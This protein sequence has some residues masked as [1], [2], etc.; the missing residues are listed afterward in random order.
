L[1][2]PKKNKLKLLITSQTNNLILVRDFITDAAKNFGFREEDI[3]KITLAVD[4]ACTNI[5]KHAY[6][7]K[8][9]RPIEI[10]VKMDN[11]KFVVLIKDEGK[12][13]EP[14][15]IILPNVKEHIKQY[16]VGGLGIYLMK[17]LMDEVKYKIVPGLHN[18]VT[19]VKYLQ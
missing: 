4:E 12:N 18:E 8:P 2:R 5:I 17:S 9:D 15:S 7:Y 1:Q 6:E 10:S 11:N 13:F 19:L 14:S 3:N 16:K